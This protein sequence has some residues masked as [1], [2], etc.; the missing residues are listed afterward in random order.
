MLLNDK[1]RFDCLTKLLHKLQEMLIGFDSS[2]E[3]LK[4]MRL[5]Q[6]STSR[7]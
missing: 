2:T 4:V 5:F 7:S 3:Q 1:I 6:E